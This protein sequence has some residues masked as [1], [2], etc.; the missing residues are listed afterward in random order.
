MRLALLPLL[1]ALTSGLCAAEPRAVVGDGLFTPNHAAAL[2]AEAC[3]ALPGRTQ[4]SLPILRVGSIANHVQ[5]WKVAET[6]RPGTAHYV[7]AFKERI[8]IGTVLVHG[9]WTVGYL[10]DD[11]PADAEK[12]ALW[13]DVPYPGEAKHD[14]RVVP[15]PPGVKTKAVR[16][17]GPLQ[18]NDSG[19]FAARLWLACTFAPRFVNIAPQADVTVG[20]CGPRDQGFQPDA[21]KNTPEVL[22]DGALHPHWTS[23]Q[24]AEPLT[25][26]KPEWALLDWGQARTVRG[27]ALFMNGGACGYGQLRI[28]RYA[29]QDRPDPHNAAAWEV[30]GRLDFKRPWRPEVWEQ[31]CDFGKPVSTRALRFVAIQGMTRERAAGDEGANAT[32]M[33]LSEVMAFEDL[34]NRPAPAKLVRENAIPEGVVPIAF[35]LPQA[36]KVSIQILNEK[37]EVVEHLLTG[38]EFPAGENTA[39][40]DLRTLNEFWPPFSSEGPHARDPFAGLPTMAEPGKYRWHGIWHPGLRLRY[41]YSFYPLKKHGLAW[42]TADSTGGWLADHTPPQ[43]VVRVGETMFVGTFCEAGHALLQADLDMRKRWGSNRIWLACPRV[44]AV[45]GDKLYYLDQGGWVGKRVVLIQVDTRTKASRRLMVWDFED[46]RTYANQAAANLSDRKNAVDIQ[47]LAVVGDRA[48]FSERAHN[49]IR[50]IDLSKTLAAKG[51]GFGWEEAKK[52]HDEEKMRVVKDVP[53]AQPGRIRPYDQKRLAVVSDTSVLLLDRETLETQPLVTGLTRPLGLAVDPQR[54]LYVGEM[55]PVHQVKVFGP[56][57]KLLRLVGKPG[58]HRIGPFDVDN[59]ESPAGLEVDAKGNLWVCEFNEELKRTSVWGPD[60]RCLDQVIGPTQYGGGGDIDPRDENRFFYQGQEFR[61]DPK[62]G[63]VRLVNLMWRADDGT[64]D[65]FFSGADHNFGGRAPAYPFYNGE[66]LFFTAWQGWA[67]G[68]NTTLYLYDRGRIRPVAAIGTPPEWLWE[69]LGQ[70]KPAPK[71]D[72]P[73]TVFVWTDA[74]D[75]GKVQPEEARLGRL[76]LNGKTWPN[77]G[78]TWQFRMN[79]KFEAAVSDGGYG[80]A[81]IAFFRVERLNE[82]GYPVYRLPTEFHAIPRLSHAADAVFTTREGNAISLDEMVTCLRPDGRIL[83]Q[84]KNRWPGLHAGHH[85]TAQG[86][87]PGVLIAATRFPG[88]AWV[89]DQVGE[90]IDIMSNLGGTCFMTTDGLFIDRAFQD[91]RRGLA[92]RTDEPPADEVMTRMSLGDEHFGG[93]FQKVRCADGKDRFRFVVGQ[94]HCSVVEVD[95]LERIRRMPGGEFTVSAEQFAAAEK[96]RQRRA[97]AKAQPKRYTIRRAKAVT[98]DGKSDEWPGE[99]IDG[100][101]LGYDD[102]NLYVLFDGKDDRAVFRNAATEDGYLEAF[103]TGDVVDVLLATKAG[104][105][106]GRDAGGEGDVRLSLVPI[107]GKPTAVLYEFV[108]P[109]TPPDRRLSFSSPWRTLYIDRV[110]VLTDATI[111]IQ[112]RTDGYTLEAAVPLGAIGLDPKRT[113]RLRGDVGRVLSDQTGTRAVDRV[114]WSD[115]S[116]K[117]VSDVPS[118]AAVHPNLWGTFEFEP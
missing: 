35:T 67:A 77:V 37:D 110:R 105:K 61:R 55:D 47:G 38:H 96:L 86:D 49:R 116:T 12:D 75:D 42:I 3:Y 53:V 62:T 60:G 19:K 17:S 40:W 26:E 45:D 36:G 41:L 87:E 31:Y 21:R 24:R 109:G 101:A 7:L 34:E 51:R 89:N 114:Y 97:L 92:W 50:V 74:N 8:P 59:L 4:P 20:S 103:K 57:G 112:R 104:G 52:V 63:E 88:G 78:A 115:Q 93:T 107:G 73:A 46:D 113:P 82:K 18:P 99:R 16:L 25:E 79:E 56:D 71:K 27:C 100:F 80:Q 32:A 69:R 91:T 10:K 33:G 65:I 68:G 102:R 81:A 30:V 108:V 43:D 5:D 106:E 76:T 22:N 13:I 23:G 98:V 9:H 14:L 90:V 94:P 58:R 84:Y 39:W 2:D 54:N 85:T 6:N 111:A 15:F 83:W 11:G 117:I 66:K 72:P 48:F 95:G 118:E 1:C 29:G 70:P 64:H 28:E 44:M